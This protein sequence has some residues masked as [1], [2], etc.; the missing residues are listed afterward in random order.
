M[1]Q[2][3][4]Q[5]LRYDVREA[6]AFIEYL[7]ELGRDGWQIAVS[8]PTQ[9]GCDLILMRETVKPTT[10]ELKAAFGPEFDRLL[11]HDDLARTCTTA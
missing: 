9:A 7:N 10:I 4:Y 2:F 3:E 8:L 5:G 1:K 6:A 11:A